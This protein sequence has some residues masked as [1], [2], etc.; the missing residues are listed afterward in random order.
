MRKRIIAPVIISLLLALFTTSAIASGNNR[1]CANGSD[2]TLKERLKFSV[3]DYT[4]K[5]DTNPSETFALETIN[6]SN[7]GENS[8]T[9]ADSTKVNSS[10]KESH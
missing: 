10:A 9:E 2:K 4:G 1:N 5:E 6:D 7:S 8:G 3:S